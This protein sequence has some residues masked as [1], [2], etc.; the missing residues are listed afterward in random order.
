MAVAAD[1]PRRRFLYVAPN[2][3]QRR[4]VSWRDV[5][6]QHVLVEHALEGMDILLAGNA[7]RLVI[8]PSASDPEHDPLF[9]PA[10]VW[11]SVAD[12]QVTRYR[13]RLTDE[14]ALTSDVL[15]ELRRRAWPRYRVPSRSC[16]YIVGREARSL[17]V[18][19]SPSLRPRPVRCSLAVPHTGAVD[20]SPAPRPWTSEWMTTRGLCT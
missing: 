6:E 10:R 12:N 17:A 4:G 11:Q 19:A 16:Q 15:T 20:Y 13:R 3:L 8:P 1:L 7:G 9:A 14:Q 5:I 2:W 18:C